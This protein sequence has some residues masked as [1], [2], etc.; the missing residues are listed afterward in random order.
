M[1]SGAL[2]LLSALVSLCSHLC[3]VIEVGE[4]VDVLAG[5]GR[6]PED[7]IDEQ[8]QHQ[9]RTDQIPDAEA[10]RLAVVRVADLGLIL[11]QVHDRAR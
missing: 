4:H 2:I 10:V 1:L 9:T 11:H 7:V 3:E 5:H 6:L 8:R